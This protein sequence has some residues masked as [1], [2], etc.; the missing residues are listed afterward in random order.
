[1]STRTRTSRGYG[2]TSYGR[3]GGYGEYYIDGSTAKRI[4]VRKAIQE[5]PDER[6]ERQVQRKPRKA[7]GMNLSYVAFMA[8]ALCTAAMVL[9]GYIRIQAENTAMLE[10]IARKESQLNSMRLAND[11]EYSRIV[12]SV[13]LEYVKDVAINQ[14]GMKYAEEG[15]IVEVQVQGDDYVRQYQEMP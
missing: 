15:Q 9:I 12:S 10:S 7:R 8:V 14:L 1:M 13:D 3:R 4:D 5:L 6:S 11:E 2:E